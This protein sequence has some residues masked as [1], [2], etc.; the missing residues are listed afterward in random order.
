MQNNAIAHSPDPYNREYPL[1]SGVIAN[2]RG[3]SR[4]IPH[5]IP[6][7]NDLVQL[8]GQFQNYYVHMH[9]VPGATLLNNLN[10]V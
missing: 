6:L 8:G 3:H 7:I 5:S 10:I 9:D 1:H 4:S 2:K